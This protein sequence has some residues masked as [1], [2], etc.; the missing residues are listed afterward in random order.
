MSDKTGGP[1]FPGERVVYRAGYAT[2]ETEPVAGMTL[3]DYVAAKALG[4][5]LADP[6]SST[7]SVERVAAASYEYA[8]AMLAERS[9]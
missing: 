3:R 4:G 7:T 6:A 1:A 2:K 5:I 8:D 9:K